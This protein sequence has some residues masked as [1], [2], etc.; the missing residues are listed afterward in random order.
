MNHFDVFYS[1]AAVPFAVLFAGKLV[2]IQH[3]AYGTIAA[4]MDDYVSK[5]VNAERMRA[6]IEQ[7]APRQRVH[8]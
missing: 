3:A 5:P 2:A 6:V 8:V 7:W 4:G 1:M